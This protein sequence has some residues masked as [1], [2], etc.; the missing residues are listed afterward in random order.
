MLLILMKCCAD[1]SF[2]D[3]ISF[4]PFWINCCPFMCDNDIRKRWPNVSVC[5]LLPDGMFG[6]CHSVPAKEIYTYDVSPSVVQRFRM[7]LEKLSNRGKHTLAL[8]SSPHMITPPCCSFVAQ[9]SRLQM[10][11]NSDH[12]LTREDVNS[13]DLKC[14]D[15]IIH[16]MMAAFLAG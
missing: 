15:C 1:V 10:I 7:L 4:L 14:A 2:T 12:S 5:L 6:R 8:R 9:L 11:F 16:F 3:I 13:K